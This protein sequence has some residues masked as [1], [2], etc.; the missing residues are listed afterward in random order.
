MNVRHQT[1]YDFKASVIAMLIKV[2][3]LHVTQ[4]Q[5]GGTEASSLICRAWLPPVWERC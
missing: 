1:D 3:L 4:E 2:A 5:K